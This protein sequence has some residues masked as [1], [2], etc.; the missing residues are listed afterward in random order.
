M[1]PRDC[2]HHQEHEQRGGVTDSPDRKPASAFERETA[3]ND[4]HDQQHN[5]PHLGQEHKEGEF[6]QRLSMNDEI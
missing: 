5:I 1:S 2:E 4:V 3:E 6:R